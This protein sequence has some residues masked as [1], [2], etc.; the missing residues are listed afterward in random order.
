[1]KISMQVI[2]LVVLLDANGTR[3]IDGPLT[4]A[5]KVGGIC[6]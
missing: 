1:M 3:W 2:W 5:V 4:R 6:Y